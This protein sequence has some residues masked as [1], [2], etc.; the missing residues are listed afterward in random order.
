M[1]NKEKHLANTFTFKLEVFL[2]IKLV[3]FTQVILFFVL[4]L[5]CLS[6][7]STTE[8]VISPS[9]NWVLMVHCHC[10]LWLH[11]QKLLKFCKR[12]V[13]TLEQQLYAPVLCPAV[14]CLKLFHNLRWAVAP[15]W[16]G[17][18]FNEI[19]SRTFCCCLCGDF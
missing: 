12:G 9:S 10:F 18:P 16:C 15:S 6:T 3:T 13:A 17:R 7:S 14:L 2:K 5:Q 11:F 4:L 8:H 19:T 1:L